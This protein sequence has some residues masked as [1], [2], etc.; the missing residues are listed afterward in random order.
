[1]ADVL[2]LLM[3]PS[4]M[5]WVTISASSYGA[6]LENFIALQDGL[7]SGPALQTL[8]WL[9]HF[10]SDAAQTRGLGG[11][12]TW[13]WDDTLCPKLQPRFPEDLFFAPLVQCHDLKAAMHRAFDSWAA[14]HRLISFVDVTEEC[15]TLHGAVTHEAGCDLAEVWVTAREY[16]ASAQGDSIAA[17][18]TPTPTVVDDFR[19]TSGLVA[20]TSV[21]ETVGGTIEFTYQR[22]HGGDMCWYLDSAFCN[23]FHRLKAL[24]SPESVRSVGLSIVLFVTIT[25][26]LWTFI[27]VAVAFRAFAMKT[28]AK[29]RCVALLTRLNGWS[30]WCTALRFVLIVTPWL[31][32]RQIYLPCW[33]CYDFE[34][35][36]THE[37]GHLLGLS[38]PDRAGMSMS[39]QCSS[40]PALCGSQ[41]GQNLRRVAQ[42]AACNRS[43]DG[44]VA[45]AGEVQPSIMMAFTQHNPSVCLTADD[46][47]ALHTIYPDCERPQGMQ[48]VICFKSQH[49]IGLVRVGVYVLIPA[50]C[51]LLLALFLSAFMRRNQL[52]RAL[53]LG[54]RFASLSNKAGRAETRAR[55][56]ESRAKTLRQ[57]AA[58]ARAEADDEKERANLAVRELN[59]VQEASLAACLAHEGHCDASSSS[60]AAPPPRPSFLGNSSMRTSSNNN[61][62][63]NNEAPLRSTSS[64]RPPYINM[65]RASLAK[66]LKRMPS[67]APPRSTSSRRSRQQPSNEE[68]CSPGQLSS[69]PSSSQSLVDRLS[70]RHD[71]EATSMQIVEEAENGDHGGS[72]RSSIASSEAPGGDSRR[73]TSETELPSLRLS[74]QRSS[75][76]RRSTETIEE[77]DAEYMEGAG[78]LAP[79]RSSMI[80]NFV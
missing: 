53:S 41:S 31:F 1:M 33:D 40:D 3:L 64:F 68:S 10:P 34:A 18:A 30:M 63:I 7:Y 59:A 78:A 76:V 20:G 50:L 61:N 70:H 29:H 43:F 21:V 13:A 6:S 55:L 44:L 42:P 22:A 47:D 52:A 77:D 75:E 35:A 54:N 36:A 73:M 27:Q 71:D 60:A 25:A 24:S 19:S 2:L 46:L 16:D 45:T 8:G 28:D 67:F 12:I 38:H 62:N 57:Q 58:A 65:L 48:E 39:S 17:L 51:A 72:D 56:A 26:G 49:N 23:Q 15:R 37:V 14:N 9:W 79:R 66:S 4:A 74:A 80:S 5:G 32:Y 11:S 69:A